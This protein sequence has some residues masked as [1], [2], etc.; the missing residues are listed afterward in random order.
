MAGEA[1]QQI[2]QIGK[3]TVEGTAVAATRKMY[4]TGDFTR[5]RAQNV[6]QV[7]TGTRDNQRDSKLRAVAAGGKLMMPIGADEIIEWFLALIQGPVTPVTL[8]GAT[9]WTFK[10]GNTIDSQT[11]EYFDG[12]RAWVLRGTKI[13]ELKLSGTVDG[14]TKAE[15]TFFAREMAVGALTAAL[16]DRVPDFTEGWELQ[17]FVDAFGATPGTTNIPGTIISWDITIK[18]NLARKYFGDNTLAAGGVVL[19]NLDVKVDVT[20]EANASAMAEYTNFD[21]NTKRLV[22]LLI[23]NNG[24]VLGTSALKKQIT[25][26]VPLAWGAVDLGGEDKG[27]K[28]YKF[29]GTYIY[30]PTNAFGLQAKVVTLRATAY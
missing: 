6:V 4:T 9:T 17:L 1:W 21:G 25:I 15:A 19:G 13:D 8:L 12:Y 5:T 10:P 14:D 18:N 16:P 30:D 28:V 23:G 26:D 29:S 20:L 24:A 7:Q 3:E 27:T 11:Y 2:T 22:R